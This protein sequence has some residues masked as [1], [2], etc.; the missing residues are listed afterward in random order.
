MTSTTKTID[1]K[2]LILPKNFLADEERLKQMIASI[3]EQG[4]F[5]PILIK[6][7]MTVFAGRLRALAGQRLGVT[8]ECKIYPSGLPEEEY[9]TLSLHENLKR[10]NLPWYDQIALEK[11]LHDLRQSQEGVAKPGKKVGW[12]LRDTAD[13]LQM[14]FGVLSEDISMAK[15]IELD[16]SLKRITDKTQAKKIIFERIKRSNQETDAQFSIAKVETNVVHNGGSEVILQSYPNCTFDACIT[17]PPWLEFKDASLVRD[18][19]TLPVFKEV[20]RVLKVNSFLYMFVSTQDW[21]FYQKELTAIGFTVQKYPLIWIK[22]GVLTYGTR[23]WEYQRDYEPILLAVKG[24]PAVTGN[25]LSSIIS[26]KVV[27]SALLKH[28]NEKPVA[29]IQRILDHCSYEGSLILD[30]FCG[31]GVVPDVCRKN[32]RKYVAIEKD[33]KYYDGILKRLE[34]KEKQS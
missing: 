18:A 34:I 20:Y 19:F 22:E 21:I 8:L 16:P 1:S 10:Y 2:L 33:A 31:S 4:L 3:K 7:D 9:K 29:V 13:E 24:S 23:S 12:S 17:D 25:M 32:R 5:H 28:P 26:C 27:P 14:A 15:A 30:P 6:D 11:E